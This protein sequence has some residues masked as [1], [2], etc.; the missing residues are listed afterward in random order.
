MLHQFIFHSVC[1]QSS[2]NTQDSQTLY[3]SWP[4]QRPVTVYTAQDYQDTQIEKD[5]F[6]LPPQRYSVRGTGSTP[7]EN[8][9]TDSGN[10]ADAGRFWQYREMLEK[11]NDIGIIVQASIIDDGKNYPDEQVY[12]EVGSLLEGDTPNLK[13]PTPW[14]L[15]AGDKSALKK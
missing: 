3:W 14:P 12:L 4:A 10:L 8:T 2:P 6:G 9:P 5:R 15:V 7:G 1:N 13:D 11:W